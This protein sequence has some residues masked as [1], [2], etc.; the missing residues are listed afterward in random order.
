MAITDYFADSAAAGGGDGTTAATSGAN[1][2]LTLSEMVTQINGLGAGG[3]AGRR[4]N[5]KGSH[6]GRGASDTI[7]VGG[8]TTA[9]L[10]IRGYASTIGDATVARSSGGALDTTN[11]P[12]I[13]YNSGFRLIISGTYTVVE[14]LDIAGN[15]SAYLLDLTATGG[16]ATN[17][18]AVNSSTNASSGGIR[19]QGTT[20]CRVVNCDAETGAS[21][22]NAAIRMDT[23]T[24]YIV[25]CRATS[26]G[27]VGINVQGGSAVVGNTV[28]DC[29]TDG[30]SIASGAGTPIINNTVYGC[31]GD[32]ID[33]AAANPADLT[34]VGN[35]VTDNGGYGFNMNGATCG[36]FAAHN[37]T[38]DNTSG[39]TSGGADW[40]AGTSIRHVTTDTGG[41]S[42]D[43]TDTTTDDYS[44]IAA[45]PGIS[46]NVGYLCDIGANGTPVVTGGGGGVIGVIGG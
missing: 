32:G 42:T 7:S 12:D 45:A 8:T 18:R 5:V 14:A 35:H 29:G 11:M 19:I 1:G 9:P 4:Y 2:A 33:V 17:C 15:V 25:G 21:G 30:I 6:T 44:L 3:G 40:F 34:F 23:T 36:V 46:G 38:R 20:R 41:P 13:G 26:P 22:G 37:R 43:Y 10:V 16:A 39:A 24:G 27:A 28:H 31:A